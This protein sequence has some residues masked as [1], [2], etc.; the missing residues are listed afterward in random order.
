MFAQCRFDTKISGPLYGSRHGGD[1]LNQ[2]SKVNSKGNEVHYL[3]AICI[4]NKHY[5]FYMLDFVIDAL[6]SNII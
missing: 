3:G 5:N 1:K 2:I 6:Y 4:W